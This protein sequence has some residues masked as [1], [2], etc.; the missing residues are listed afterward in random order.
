L[1][2]A[3]NDP[4]NAEQR[5]ASPSLDFVSHSSSDNTYCSWHTASTDPLFSAE[6]LFEDA[7]QD[8]HDIVEQEANKTDSVI[9]IA[10]KDLYEL[11][12]RQA[13]MQN[14]LNNLICSSHGKPVV[15]CLGMQAP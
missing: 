6:R 8:A 5:P 14:I 7:L 12:N 9:T 1:F 10:R 3:A 2:Q 13:L 11:K 15:T 4:L